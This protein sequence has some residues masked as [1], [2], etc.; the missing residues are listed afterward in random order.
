MDSVL[1]SWF[2]AFLI[3]VIVTLVLVIAVVLLPRAIRTRAVTAGLYC[4]WQRR[5]VVLRYLVGEGDRPAGVISCTAFADPGTVTCVR[6]CLAGDGPAALTR[7]EGASP[8]PAAADEP[9]QPVGA[10]GGGA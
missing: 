9:G 4:P 6:E 7:R 1:M 5:N 10:R 8:E 2:V 3:G